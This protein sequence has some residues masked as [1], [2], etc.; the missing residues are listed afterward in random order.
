MAYFYHDA[1]GF[2]VTEA[3]ISDIGL[4]DTSVVNQSEIY[5]GL[6]RF[7]ELVTGE[8]FTEY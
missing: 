3:T 6:S 7:E 2:C 1:C 8:V 4:Y 5:I